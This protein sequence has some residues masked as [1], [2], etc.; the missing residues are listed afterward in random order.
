MTLIFFLTSFVVL[1]SIVGYGLLFFKIINFEKFSY[2][3][4]LTG[5]LGLF[6]LSLILSYDHLIISH[7]YFHNIYLETLNF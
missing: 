5:F 3:F 6:F 2:N 1:I 7:N 4:G